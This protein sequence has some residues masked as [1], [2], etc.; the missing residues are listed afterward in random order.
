VAASTYSKQT[1]PELVGMCLNGDALAWEALIMRYRRFIYSIP[2]KF[3]FR[4]ADASDV[5]Q[6][7]CLKLIEHLHEVKDENKLS[8]WLATIKTRQ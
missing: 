8:A 6:T 7:V 3:G 2:V 5:F 4:A 1:D